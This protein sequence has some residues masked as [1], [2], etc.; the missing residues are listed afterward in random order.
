M[1]KA[2]L[3]TRNFMFEAYGSTKE[4]ALAC[5]INGW[6]NHCKDYKNASS[7]EDISVNGEEVC[8]F[9]ILKGKCYRDNELVI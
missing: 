1:I 7:F 9:E 4:E 8:Y 5:L 6:K 2:R 3:E